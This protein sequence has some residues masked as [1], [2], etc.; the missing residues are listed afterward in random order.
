MP[1]LLKFKCPH[2]PNLSIVPFDR[3]KILFDPM[4]YNSDMLA[5]HIDH[6]PRLHGPVHYIVRTESMERLYREGV[7][8]VPLTPRYT[9]DASL[10]IG[11]LIE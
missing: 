9:N 11:G 7:D 2:C 5:V 3:I 10:V 8:M 4:R 1:E 6:A